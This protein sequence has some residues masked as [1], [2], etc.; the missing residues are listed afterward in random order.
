M[1]LE[2]ID[3]ILIPG[4]K[5]QTTWDIVTDNAIFPEFKTIHSILSHNSGTKFNH[6]WFYK[7][8]YLLWKNWDKNTDKNEFK[9]YRITSKNSIE[10]VFPQNDEYKNRLANENDDRDWLNSFGNLA[11]LSVGQNSEYSNQ[12]VAKKKIDFK[13]KDTYDSLKL[14]KVYEFEN[15]NTKEI[16]EHQN[17]MFSVFENHYSK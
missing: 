12:D 16:I 8:E 9:R 10:H 15:W 4:D 7:L 5:K 1:E 17:A 6:Y 3:N 2:R 13:R 11:L 14:A